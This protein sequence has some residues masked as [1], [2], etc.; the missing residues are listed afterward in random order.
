MAH[1]LS[2]SVA[3]GIS[4]DQGSNPCPLHCTREVQGQIILSSGFIL[5]LIFNKFMKT[6]GNF[7]VSDGAQ[8][9]IYSKQCK[10]LY[11]ESTDNKV[12][13]YS[14]ENYI[15]YPVINHNRKEY[16]KECIYL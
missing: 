12:L 7:F 13:L 4:P 15:Q 3:C 2:C 14:T 11:M 9:S 10:L 6:L 8:D 16:E 1:G 5:N